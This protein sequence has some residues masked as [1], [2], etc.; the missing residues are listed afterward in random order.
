MH[1]PPRSP[2][3]RSPLFRDTEDAINPRGDTY[4]PPLPLSSLLHDADDATKPRGKIYENERKIAGAREVMRSVNENL[5]AGRKDVRFDLKRKC[6]QAWVQVE[7]GALLP[8]SD[9]PRSKSAAAA[10]ATSSRPATQTFEGG[11]SAVTAP[12]VGGYGGGGGGGGST[13]AVGARSGEEQKDEV[14]RYVE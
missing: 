6:C 8:P 2:F 10:A 1:L 13:A 3:S 9:L 11:G 12:P 4:H 14:R 5:E 7:Y